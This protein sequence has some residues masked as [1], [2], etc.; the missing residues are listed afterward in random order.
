MA[1]AM[2]QP[3]LKTP[4]GACDCHMHIFDSRFPLAAK[5]RRQEKDASVADYRAVQKRL[6]L[7]R[8]VVVQPTAYGRD[9]R[10]TLE[11]IDFRLSSSMSA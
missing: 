4:S 10:C 2:N 11:A 5:A 1:I 6:G 9:N 3:K 8:V 7:E